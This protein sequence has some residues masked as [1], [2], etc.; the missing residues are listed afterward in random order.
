MTRYTYAAEDNES[1]YESDGGTHYRVKPVGQYQLQERP[2]KNNY[3]Y[4]IIYLSISLNKLMYVIKK[5]GQLFTGE[6]PLESL[7][8]DVSVLNKSI[9]EVGLI[10][11]LGPHASQ[12]ITIL[13]Q[14]KHAQK[15]YLGCGQYSLAREF[16]SEDASNTRVVLAPV[17]TDWETAH[18]EV[19]CKQRFF[20][21]TYP[22]EKACLDIN[23]DA[24]TYRLIVHKKPGVLYKELS[25]NDPKQQIMLC[26]STVK[27]LQTTHAAGNVII[28]LSIS[29]IKYEPPIDNENIGT[30]YLIDGGLSVRQ[31]EIISST[32][33]DITPAKIEANIKKYSQ[34]APECWTEQN[35]PGC[36][37]NTSMDVYAMASLLMDT[38]Q[39]PCKQLLPL[40]DDCRMID[41]AQRPTLENLQNRLEE[42]LVS[43]SAELSESST[44]MTVFNS[45]MS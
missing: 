33:Q 17:Y 12:L 5:P 15:G 25:I 27:A 44:V 2:A 11:A 16:V 43:L 4:G 26:I 22:H 30:S 35:K 23:R 18:S 41:P 8:A 19:L 34:I 31:G 24:K 6:L 37:A 9:A 13:Q 29:N 38:L 45:K 36:K 3:K 28:D 39:K 10:P 14:K 32:F 7:V 20:S 42:M 21:S 1:D 40:L